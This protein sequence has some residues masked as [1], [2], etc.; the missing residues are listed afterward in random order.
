MN[1]RAPFVQKPFAYK[2]L[3]IPSV[4]ALSCKLPSPPQ[5]EGIVSQREALDFARS[6]QTLHGPGGRSSKRHNLACQLATIAH[7]STQ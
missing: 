1:S 4:R 3:R 2:C 5:E 7:T 6:L